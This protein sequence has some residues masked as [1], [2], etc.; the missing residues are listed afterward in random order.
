MPWRLHGPP[1]FTAHRR[2]ADAQAKQE[3]IDHRG[4]HS[5]ECV[6]VSHQ[7]TQKTVVETLSSLAFNPDAI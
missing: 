4:R 6:H 3:R 5:S 1:L 2:P 7:H